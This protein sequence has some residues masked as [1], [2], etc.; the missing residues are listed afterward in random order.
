[1]VRQ[2]PKPGSGGAE[3]VFDRWAQ[4]DDTSGVRGDQLLADPTLCRGVG[5][6]HPAPGA[7]ARGVVDDLQAADRPAAFGGVGRDAVQCLIHGVPPGWA[8]EQFRRRMSR[9]KSVLPAVATSRWCLP[10]GTWSGP[11]SG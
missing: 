8:G 1:M 6:R 2:A 7:A 9:A 11:D 3:A 10:D 5:A 4:A